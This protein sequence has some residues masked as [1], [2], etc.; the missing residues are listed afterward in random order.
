MLQKAVF[1]VY[2]EMLVWVLGIKRKIWI[3]NDIIISL[4]P[5]APVFFFFFVI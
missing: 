3:S 2:G 5:K 4:V 1:H